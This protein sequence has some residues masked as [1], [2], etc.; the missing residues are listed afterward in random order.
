MHPGGGG[1]EHHPMVFM[2]GVSGFIAN[3]EMIAGDFTAG[4]RMQFDELVAV[5]PKCNP[6]DT[7]KILKALDDVIYYVKNAA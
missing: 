7:D 5:I 1:F 6:H 2:D 4:A 3:T